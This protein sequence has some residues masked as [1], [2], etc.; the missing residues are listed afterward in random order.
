[1]EDIDLRLDGNA[2]AGLLSEIF[3]FQMTVARTICS[4]CGARSEVGA[5][6]V[7][8]HGMGAIVRCPGCDTAVM[9]I[10]HGAGR[11]WLDLRGTVCLEIRT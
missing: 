8:Q 2:V 6:V 1:M 3:P 9:R 10:A 5:L 11:Y 4:G 7:Y